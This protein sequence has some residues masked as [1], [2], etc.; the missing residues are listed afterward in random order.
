[1]S[2]T[3][4]Y[5]YFQPSRATQWEKSLNFVYRIC[6]H[7]ILFTPK[8][9]PLITHKIATEL[10][11]IFKE[12]TVTKGYELFGLVI[13]PNHAHVILGTRPTHF[14]PHVVK[15]IRERT[16]FLIM[17][18]H[19]DIQKQHRVKK[20]WSR[21]FGVETLGDFNLERIR[22]YLQDSKEHLFLDEWEKLFW[23]TRDGN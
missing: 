21:N 11:A 1:M 19:R 22:D 9:R 18:R 2:E 14:V 13:H 15:D 10:E 20:L 5:S 17:R 3:I 23:N 12:I 6:Y 8:Y 16:S 7:L 4:L